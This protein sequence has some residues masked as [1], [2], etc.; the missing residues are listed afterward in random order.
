MIVDVGS[1][2][3]LGDITVKPL[4]GYVYSTDIIVKHGYVIKLPDG[5]FCRFFVDSVTKSSTGAVTKIFVTWQ[6]SF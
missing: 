2:T 1:I 3:C 4:S 6:Y 5:T